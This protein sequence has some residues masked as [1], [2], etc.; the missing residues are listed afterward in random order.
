MHVFVEICVQKN[1]N[2]ILRR[3]LYVVGLN[4]EISV[5]WVIPCYIQ[6]FHIIAKLS[7]LIYIEQ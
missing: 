4:N 3:F 7:L 6:T 2:F 5:F 1:T